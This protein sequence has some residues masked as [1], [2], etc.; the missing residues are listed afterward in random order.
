M[1]HIVTGDVK[2]K[3]TELPALR[4]AVEH[5]GAVFAEGQTTHKWF[6][7]RTACEHAIVA[8]DAHSGQ[9]EIGLRRMPGADSFE[10]AFDTFGS[11]RWIRDTFGGDLGKLHDRFLAEV[12]VDEFESMGMVTQIEETEHGLVIEG[13]S[14]AV[15]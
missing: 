7:G 12:A 1:S 15:E 9:Y 14:Y 6:Q 3:A 11:G 2:I 13:V 8:K 5:L 4:R 10:L